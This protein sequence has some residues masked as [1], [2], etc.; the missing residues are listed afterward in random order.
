MTQ[1]VMGCSVKDCQDPAK[2]D[3]TYDCGKDFPE[4]RMLVCPKHYDSYEMVMGDNG[5]FEKMHYYKQ[6]VKDLVVLQ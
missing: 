2:Y 3:I 1:Q 6:F 5:E 4:Q